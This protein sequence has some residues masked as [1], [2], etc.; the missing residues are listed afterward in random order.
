[1]QRASGVDM[2]DLQ[3]YEEIEYRPK[4]GVASVL[5]ARVPTLMGRVSIGRRVGAF[6]LT[7][8]LSVVV[9]GAVLAGD[10]GSTRRSRAA[11]QRVTPE[12]KVALSKKGLRF[13]APIFLRVFKSEKVLE[14]WV[15]K[16]S[17]FERFKTYPIC[18]FSGGLGPKTKEGDGMAPEGFYEVGARAMNPGSSYH[19]S[20][21]LGYPN[22]F[23]R[24]HRRTG[25]Y[26][27]VHGECVS[28]GCYAMTNPGIEEIWT[29]ADAALR[30]GQSRF[31]AHLFPFRMTTANMDK[32]KE[33]PHI[34]F[35]KNLKVGYDKFE[36]T[37][38]PPRVKVRKKRYVF[39]R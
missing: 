39:A 5:E 25:S 8:F 17:K 2:S 37:K 34:D 19:L 15:K 29:L 21:N 13:G 36:V 27:M 30:G 22:S 20:F 26:L 14:V 10:P 38:R 9:A 3:L 12:L 6:L 1:M 16:G 33:S 28:I 11:V 24:A 32:H 23:D 31:K 7:L 35:W 18:T 4:L